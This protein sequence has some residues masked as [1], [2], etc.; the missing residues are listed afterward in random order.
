M[1]LDVDIT[2]VAGQSLEHL[3]N[4]TNKGVRTHDVGL[5]RV[6]ACLEPWN[7]TVQRTRTPISTDSPSGDCVNCCLRCQSANISKLEAKPLVGLWY[8][9]DTRVTSGRKIDC[10]MYYMRYFYNAYIKS[11]MI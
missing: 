4:K 10:L 5:Y 8:P 11:N 6:V 9:S 1:L 2:Q 3:A 7:V